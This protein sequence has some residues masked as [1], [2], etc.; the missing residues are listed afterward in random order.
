MTDLEKQLDQMT[1]EER[2]QVE[3]EIQRLKDVTGLQDAADALASKMEKGLS[4]FSSF[5]SDELLQI[6]DEAMKD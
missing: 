3:A 5:E 2:K 4:A 1:P 6:L